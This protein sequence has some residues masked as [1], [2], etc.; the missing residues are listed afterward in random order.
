MINTESDI[1]SIAPESRVTRLGRW[2][3]A[4]PGFGRLAVHRTGRALNVLQQ[5]IDSTIKTPAVGAGG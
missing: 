4:P 2:K 1:V 5:R 3:G